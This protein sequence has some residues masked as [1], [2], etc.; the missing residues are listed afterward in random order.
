VAPNAEPL[1]MVMII[2]GRGCLISI[3][4]GSSYILNKKEIEKMAAFYKDNRKKGG[5]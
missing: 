3:K 5:A 2:I 4:G 1:P